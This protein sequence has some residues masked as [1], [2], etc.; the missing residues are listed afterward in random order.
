MVL[1]VEVKIDKAL[2]KLNRLRNNITQKGD[3]TVNELADLGKYYA[4]SR[5][6]HYTGK[7]ADFI[8]AYRSKGPSGAEARV[9]ARNPTASDGHMRRMPNFNLVRWMHTSPRAVKHIY[10]GDRQ[11]MYSTRDYLNKIKTGVAQGRF[12]GINLR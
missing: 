1:R 12:K 10:S 4:R 3:A 11:F 9:V 5:A 8:I 2:A 6:P 7:T